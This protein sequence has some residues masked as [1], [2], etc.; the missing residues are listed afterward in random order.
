MR[1]GRLAT[2]CIVQPASSA[3]I[4]RPTA[5]PAPQVIVDSEWLAVSYILA[6]IFFILSLKGL[7]TEETAIFGCAKLCNAETARRR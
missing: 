2:C 4:D 1:D 5:N 3:L 6:A 7:G